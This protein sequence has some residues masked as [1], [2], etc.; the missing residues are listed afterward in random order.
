MKFFAV[1]VLSLISAAAAAPSLTLGG[2]GIGAAGDLAGGLAGKV[3][4]GGSV[5]AAAKGA[6]NAARGIAEKGDAA[7]NSAAEV[8]R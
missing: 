1:I 2:A 5:G 3:G 6:G 8:K 7:V 4:L